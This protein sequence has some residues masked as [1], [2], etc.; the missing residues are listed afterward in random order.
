ML[1]VGLA[2]NRLP[3]LLPEKARAFTIFTT[4]RTPKHPAYLSLPFMAYTIRKEQLG[5]SYFACIPLPFMVSWLDSALVAPK[6]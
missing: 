5:F 3:S 4:H 2:C 6:D 1:A